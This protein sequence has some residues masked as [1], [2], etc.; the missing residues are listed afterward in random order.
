METLVYEAIDGIGHA[1]N[2]IFLTSGSAQNYK[3]QWH[4]LFSKC[5]EYYSN[6]QSTIQTWL[7]L[8]IDVAPLFSDYLNNWKKVDTMPMAI[9]TAAIWT[10][11]QI[12]KWEVDEV[13][14]CICIVI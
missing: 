9:N 5:V 6:K 14:I 4:L 13:G 3:E 2:Y 10:E 1:T 8:V 11:T 7:S 12:P